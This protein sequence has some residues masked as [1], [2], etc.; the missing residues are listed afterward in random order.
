MKSCGWCEGHNSG[1]VCG[2]LC[3]RGGGVEVR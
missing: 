1:G 3:C 2:V